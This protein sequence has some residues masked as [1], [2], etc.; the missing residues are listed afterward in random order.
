MAIKSCKFSGSQALPASHFSGLIQTP[1]RPCVPLGCGVLWLH[2]VGVVAVALLAGF[3]ASALSPT[4]FW[5]IP[6]TQPLP[7]LRLGRLPSQP[8]SP[9]VSRGFRT[10]T[11]GPEHRR[12]TS[13]SADMTSRNVEDATGS[14]P[15]VVTGADPTALPT[16]AAT[17]SLWIALQHFVPAL[18]AF[19]AFGLLQRRLMA[20]GPR[21]GSRAW[22]MMAEVGERNPGQGA[23]TPAH[24]TAAP[25]AR[26][27]LPWTPMPYRTV[28]VA[29][30][31]ADV[32]G[33]REQLPRSLEQWAAEGFKSCM[34]QLPIEHA[35][36]AAF[37]AEHGFA[38]HHAEGRHAVLKRWLQP[39][40]EDRVPPYAT[41][42]VGIAGLVLDGAGRIL[43]VREWRDSPDGERV[44]SLRWKLPGGLLD[45]GESFEE[46]A[47]R[48]VREE[49]G[50]DTR[51]L[52]I[53]S[54]W[55]RH[56]LS[57]GQSD[58]YYVARLQLVDEDQELSPQADE[59]SDVT[60][61]PIE[62]F[63]AT[64]SHPL[65]R[66]VLTNVYGI[67][68]EP[69]AGPD[70]SRLTPQVEMVQLEGGVQ[71][72]GREPYPTYISRSAGASVVRQEADA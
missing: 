38:F 50:L 18:V 66:A 13:I 26:S 49:T 9:K 17:H 54:F 22:V 16:A 21:G 57:W 58:L 2:L 60:W 48:E 65:I 35:A 12:Q 63:M 3:A 39:T 70:D 67:G 14:P 59:I 44:P 37:A 28:R 64:Q 71:W 36:L 5:S 33:F 34:L 1:A 56:D 46:A 51:C 4:L 40:L 8:H 43:L 20:S 61:M 29:I 55:H 25:D 47:T 45:R 52:S 23:D 15:K 31:D 30:T 42:Q 11:D 69:A 27:L 41:H 68:P 32:P 10:V 6:N 62:E 72:P 7:R 24:A 19:G 53:L